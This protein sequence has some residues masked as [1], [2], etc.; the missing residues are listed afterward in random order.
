MESDP[1]IV[2]ACGP[3]VLIVTIWVIWAVSGIWLIVKAFQ[4]SVVTGLLY[5]FV[6]FYAIYFW[7]TR[8]QDVQK[9]LAIF[10]LISVVFYGLV[11][12]TDFSK[13]AMET[14]TPSMEVR[15]S[16]LPI[17]K[18]LAQIEV[19]IELNRLDDATNLII[20]IPSEGLTTLQLNRIDYLRQQISQ[21][22]HQ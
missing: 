22:R 12:F 16:N 3:A 13:D 20:T 2:S 4:E 1:S 19:L 7:I 14:L 11:F 18:K 9:P 5:L 6:P 10:L 8:F 17:D 15:G 21:K